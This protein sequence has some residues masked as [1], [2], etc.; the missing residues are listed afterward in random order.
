[1]DRYSYYKQ[2][3][4]ME[5]SRWKA[6]IELGAALAVFVGLIFVAIELRQNNDH[7]RAESIRDLFQM[8]GDIFRFEYENNRITSY[9]VCYTKLLRSDTPS[10]SSMDFLTSPGILFSYSNR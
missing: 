2:V 5:N 7:A 3:G 10:A 4:E 1:M 6:W 9:N 8:W